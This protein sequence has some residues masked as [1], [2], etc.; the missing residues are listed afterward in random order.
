MF[1]KKI[2]ALFGSILTRI[3]PQP[4]RPNSLP[5]DV[6]RLLL[7]RPGGIG[8]AVLLVPTI[9]ALR[10]AY[11]H[12]VLHV[13]AERR[14]ASVFQLASGVTKIFCYDRPQDLLSVVFTSYDV[15][16]DTEQ[17]HRL[18]AIV[19]RLI[20]SNWK[21]GFATNDRG[22]MLTHGISYSHDDYELESF[23]H[24]LSP[25]EMSLPEH[26]AVPFLQ[27]SAAAQAEADTLIGAIEKPFV[28]LFP[29]ASIPERRWGAK[30]FRELTRFLRENGFGV[31]VVGGK[32]DAD[33]GDEI[34]KAGGLNLAGRTSLQE[35]AAILL[36]CTLLISGDSGVLHLAVGLGTP[37]VSLFGPGIAAKWAPR[38]VSHGVINKKLTCSPCTRFGTTPKCSI[39]AKCL[40]DISVDEVF[41]A[42]MALVKKTQAQKAN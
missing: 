34:M 39:D 20:R 35:T 7:I 14:N 10:F 36:K 6:R 41:G 30:K 18:S 17:W 29:G 12:A 5:F 11:P 9:R 16:I 22:R 32:D 31:V 37:T 40:Q 8:D 19:T 13:L 21:I 2:D 3:L 42:I 15:I 1:L 25:L 38:E 28:V 27:V 24:L 33:Q 4:D 23:F 26:V